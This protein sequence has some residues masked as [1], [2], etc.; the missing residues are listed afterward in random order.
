MQIYIYLL[1]ITI[2][3]YCDFLRAGSMEVRYAA[4]LC[5]MVQR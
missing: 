3:N 5:P 2:P 1:C 4:S